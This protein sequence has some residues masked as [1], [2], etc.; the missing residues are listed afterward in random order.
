MASIQKKSWKNLSGRSKL[1]NELTF[2]A[3]KD[4]MRRK[5]LPQEDAEKVRKKLAELGLSE[6]GEAKQYLQRYGLFYLK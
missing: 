2:L 4:W 5:R 3:L 1:E 6:L